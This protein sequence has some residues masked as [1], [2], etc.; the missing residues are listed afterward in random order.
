MM[1]PA[2][3]RVETKMLCL[4]ILRDNTLSLTIGDGIKNMECWICGDIADSREHLIK[5]SDIRGYFGNISK[6]RPLYKHTDATDTSINYRINSTKSNILKLKSSICQKCNNQLTQL[7]DCA[8][9]ILSRYLQAEWP[10]IVKKGHF[11]FSNVFTEDTRRYALRTHLYFVK[12]FG[13]KILEEKVPINT[14]RLSEA[15]IFEKPHSQVFLTFAN[16]P[17]IPVD[18][19]QIIFS[20]RIQF[21]NY[22]SCLPDIALWTYMLH[23]VSIRISYLSRSSPHE[24]RSRAWHPSQ[25]STQVRLGNYHVSAVK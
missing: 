3:C 23:P 6:E 24:Y 4:R 20:S 1:R 22:D 14:G 11:S 12:L 15:L 2:Q 7:Y 9:E 10:T 13:C 21:G 19:D 18:D 8:W 25:P 5:A 16:A 17:E